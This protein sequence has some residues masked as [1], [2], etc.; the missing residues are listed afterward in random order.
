MLPFF[1]QRRDQMSFRTI[2]SIA[3]NLERDGGCSCGHQEG[4]AAPND[5]IEIGRDNRLASYQ[6][7]N[8]EG[9]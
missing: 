7:T 4:R 9:R 6:R 5:D 8:N 2:A 3:S 1:E